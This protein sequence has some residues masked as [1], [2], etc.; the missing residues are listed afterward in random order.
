MIIS[1]Q[2]PS[3]NGKLKLNSKILNCKLTFIHNISDLTFPFS[4][5][6]SY[7]DI[8]FQH[9]NF[10]FSKIQKNVQTA[11]K[12]PTNV[13]LFLTGSKIMKHVNLNLETYFFACVLRIGCYCFFICLN[14]DMCSLFILL[15]I[16]SYHYFVINPHR[17]SLKYTI[18]CT[19]RQILRVQC[20]CLIVIVNNVYLAFPKL[21]T[22]TQLFQD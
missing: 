14:F 6:I 10:T 3:T 11:S 17:F 21:K 13:I 7:L 5:R 4:F 2:K 19:D 16:T 9:F 12:I 22:P 15:L 20:S 1:H 8:T 18:I